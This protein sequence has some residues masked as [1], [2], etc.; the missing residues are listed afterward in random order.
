MVLSALSRG[1]KEDKGVFDECVSLYC[2]LCCGSHANLSWQDAT[3]T[4]SGPLAGLTVFLARRK[5]A[6]QE[7]QVSTFWPGLSAG[8]DYTMMR[9]SQT[10]GTARLILVF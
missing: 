7:A 9:T 1:L 6:L 10:T 3:A 4:S 5:G 8:A 2:D